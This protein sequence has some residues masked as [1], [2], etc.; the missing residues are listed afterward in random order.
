[1]L[2]VVTADITTLEVDAIVNAANEALARGGG[3]C[4]AIFRAAGPQLDAACRALAP[5]PTGEAR[6]TPGF[7]AK[8][9]WIVHAVGPVWHG[10]TA[11]EPEL[12]A[13]A[14]RSALNAAAKAGAR[15]I[16]FPAISTGIY[17]YPR[18]RAADVAIAAVKEWSSANAQPEEVIFCAFNDDDAALYDERI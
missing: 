15:S 12:L 17:G 18:D 16:A 5:C 2:R 1:M 14:Y 10:G 4:G 3:V 11:N 6:V 9:R 7:R 13:S 8:A